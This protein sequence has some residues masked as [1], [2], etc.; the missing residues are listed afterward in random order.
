MGEKKPETLNI[1]EKMSAITS[2]ITA[3][4][5]NLNVGWGSQSYK[6]VGEADVLAAVKP[7]E[8]KYRIYSYPYSRNTE[9][10]AVLTTAK[11]DGSESKQQFLRI[12]TIYRFVDMDKPDSYIDI[13]TY[14]DGVD[15]QDKAPGKAMT[16]A[17]KYALLKAYKIITGDDPDQNASEDLKDKKNKAAKP[18]E[19]NKVA[20]PAEENK[21]AEVKPIGT[22]DVDKLRA[23]FKEKGI[24][25]EFVCKLYGSKKL[26]EFTVNKYTNAIKNL[27]QIKAK[28]EEK[29][30]E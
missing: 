16:Y 5:K 22:K 17:D 23:V 9:E 24:S 20:K 7:I 15:T 8:A 25:E 19:E 21:A 18:A 28:Q 30:N 12:S 1:F 10:S 26:E 3:V 13:T 29:K 11:K 27:D 6:A 2:E 14:G 4:A